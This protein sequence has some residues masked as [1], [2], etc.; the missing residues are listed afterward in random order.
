MSGCQLSVPWLSRRACPSQFG[1]CTSC[2]WSEAELSHFVSSSRGQ[3]PLQ[4]L[5]LHMAPVLLYGGCR[6]R[7]G[8]PGVALL[9][10]KQTDRQYGRFRNLGSTFL[11]VLL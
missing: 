4:A 10:S 9:D 7:P 2:S 6:A 8:S 3:R 11:L 1:Q 5:P